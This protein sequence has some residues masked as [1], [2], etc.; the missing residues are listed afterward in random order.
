MLQTGGRIPWAKD[1][2]VWRPLPTQENINTKNLKTYAH[3]SSAI[4]TYDTIVLANGDIS[5]LRL[6]RYC[7]RRAADL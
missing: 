7:D 5:C 6:G 2:P 3:V 4:W 1:K